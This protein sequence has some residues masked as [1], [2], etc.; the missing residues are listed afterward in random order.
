MELS[1]VVDLV[2]IFA[3]VASLFF[4]GIE[5]R[6][7]RQSRKRE[8]S[9]ELFKSIKSLEFM[10]GLRTITLL[11]DDQS[12]EQ[13]EA[14]AGERMDEV[15]FMVACIE[16]MG[17]LVRREELS[18]RLVEDFFSGIIVVTWLKLRRF[19]HDERKLLNRETWMEWTQ[20]LA[21]RIMERETKKPAVPAHIE[22]RDWEPD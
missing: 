10:K 15:Y 13:F 8:S 5:L 22:Y 21:E 19:V 3:V 1:T 17:V 20:W 16:G 4:A 9:L 12:K 11:P 18:L 14:L 6:H 2:S 7:Y